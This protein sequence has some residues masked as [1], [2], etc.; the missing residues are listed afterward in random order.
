MKSTDIIPSGVIM[1]SNSPWNSILSE[2]VKKHN[3][4]GNITYRQIELIDKK[5]SDKLK[6][7]ISSESYRQWEKYTPSGANRERLEINKTL[8]AKREKAKLK[9]KTKA[10]LKKEAQKLSK[11][12][13]PTLKPGQILAIIKYAELEFNKL[14]PYYERL[15]EL[16]KIPV[17]YNK[18]DDIKTA[19]ALVTKYFAEYAKP[20]SVVEFEEIILARLYCAKK[21]LEYL[22][23][24]DI[25]AHDEVWEKTGPKIEEV[26]GKLDCK[27]LDE[28]NF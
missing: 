17:N 1:S 19:K 25:K 14:E 18:V 27:T 6:K 9:P 15:N 26:L 13:I 22:K 12:K 20:L 5:F 16:K 2:F 4:K 11:A 10:E 24:K 23:K 7:F 28:I 3:L 21:G 8:K